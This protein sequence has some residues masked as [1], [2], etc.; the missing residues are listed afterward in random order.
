MTRGNAAR[1]FRN[2]ISFDSPVDASKKIPVQRFERPISFPEASYSWIADLRPNGLPGKLGAKLWLGAYAPVFAV[3]P[4]P[5]PRN[6]IWLK[7]NEWF[8]DDV[9][10]KLRKLIL[11][12]H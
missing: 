3:L 4:H 1:P 10:P 11:Q 5:S 7:K 8:E 6:N 9:I 2:P 12:I